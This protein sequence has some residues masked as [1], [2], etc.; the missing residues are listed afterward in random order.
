MALVVDSGCSQ[1]DHSEGRAIRLDDRLSG[2]V[3]VVAAPPPESA[4]ELAW[5]FD[6][7]DGWSAEPGSSVSAA[8]GVLTVSADH[9]AAVVSPPE[10][11]VDPHA[12]DVVAVR[13]RVR[14]TDYAI[15]KWQ[16]DDLGS[17]RHRALYKIHLPE[18]DRWYGFNIRTAGLQEWH[19]RVAADDRG[20]LYLAPNRSISR[21]R[22]SVTE[23]SGLEL[24]H[25]RL[26]G[27]LAPFSAAPVGVAQHGIGS[28]IR[29][30][31]YQHSPARIAYRLTVPRDGRLATGIATVLDDPAVR[32]RV[33]VGRDGNEETLAEHELADAAR[34]HD[35]DIDLSRFAGEEVE[36]VLSSASGTTGNV[37]LWSNPVVYQPGAAQRA[38]AGR[39]PNVLVYLIDCLRADH[40]DVYGY[41]RGLA[42]RIAELAEEGVRFSS[43]STN[44]TWTKPSVS[45]LLTGVPTMV[46]G[47]L[48]YGD[49]VPDVL[50]TL[51]ETLR[52]LGIATACVAENNHIGPLSNLARGY[53]FFL[54]PEEGAPPGA[55]GEAVAPPRTI[56]RAADFLEA[57]TDRPFFL[58]VHTIEPHEPYAPPPEL[59]SRL[60]PDGADATPMDRYDAEILQADANFARLMDHL[61][62]LGLA[63]DT[64]V[65]LIADHGEAFREH[66]GMTGHGGRAY[67]ELLWVP[68]IVRWPRGLRAG[69]VVATPVQMLDIP[70]TVLDALA[71]APS[72]NHLGR[73]VL[74]LARG[75][76]DPAF[77]E[78]PIVAHGADTLA[79][80]RG[81]WKLIA[82]L[83]A[84]SSQPPSR[85]LVMDSLEG[86]ERRLFDLAED[87]G[88]TTDLAVDRPGLVAELWFE[89]EA[90]L[91]LQ[92][93]LASRAATWQ[94]RGETEMTVDPR[95]IKRLKALGYVEP[96]RGAMD[97]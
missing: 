49:T 17:Y 21:L 13:L 92:R 91:E 77:D 68:L 2:A 78:R 73:S 12:V 51:A 70:A 19:H 45:T 4:T 74:G 48:T 39:P 37:A 58:Y 96:R 80:R 57:H 69:E 36:L 89:L 60:V 88:E 82:Y 94:I 20:Q 29:S 1:G 24:D 26:L 30:C 47:V 25:M 59:L 86:A 16:V 10:L 23:G 56:E 7:P 85:E 40:L 84:D 62:R 32:F 11:G 15:L 35:L 79:V 72:E 81:N 75:E 64:L 43:F 8:D 71:A 90:T 53:S 95:A 14:D 28:E 38:A 6:D 54:D 65:L 18:P 41:H 93:A 52:P 44:E 76:K 67:Q 61:E 31:L 34:W 50:N 83:K 87:P 55:A 46:H 42:P 22:L 5:E 66:D 97:R 3:S 33:T 63:E 27:S 9:G